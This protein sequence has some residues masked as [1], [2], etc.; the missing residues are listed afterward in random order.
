MR[1]K[2]EIANDPFRLKKSDHDGRYYM[3]LNDKQHCDFPSGVCLWTKNMLMNRWFDNEGTLI[4]EYI[5]EAE[6]KYKEDLNILRKN[7]ID[8]DNMSKFDIQI[9]ISKIGR[10]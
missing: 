9:E 8:V 1:D 2:N 7:G 6:C 5:E 10:K 3:F 4:D